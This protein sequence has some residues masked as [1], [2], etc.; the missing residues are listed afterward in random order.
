M[1]K[2]ERFSKCSNG[3]PSWLCGEDWGLW[4][5]THAQHHKRVPNTY[6]LPRKP[7]QPSSESEMQFLLNTYCFCTIV[8]RKRLLTIRS[9]GLL[10]HPERD[11]RTPLPQGMKKFL[12][13]NTSFLCSSLQVGDDD[14]RHCHW[15][16]FLG[17]NGD[18]EIQNRL[19]SD[20]RRPQQAE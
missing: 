2:T 12:E 8:K 18:N 17:I 11:Q 15:N 19:C 20:T 14:G 4:L 3:L 16:T 6:C 5:A 13:G 1:R 9:Q 7:K 10:V